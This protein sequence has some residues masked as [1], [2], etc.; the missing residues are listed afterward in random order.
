MITRRSIRYL[1]FIIIVGSVAYLGMA[2]AESDVRMT[3]D[4]IQH[5]HETDSNAP[6]I[7]PRDRVT[8]VVSDRRFQGMNSALMAFAPNGSLLYYTDTFTNYHD[9]DPSPAGQRTIFVTVSD[10]VPPSE[11]SSNHP[12]TRNIFQ[13]I[14]LTTGHTKT[15]YSSLATNKVSRDCHDADRINATHYAVA[16]IADDRALIVNTATDQIDWEWEVNSSY[17]RDS[18]GAYPSDW[19]HMND[20][21]Y[22]PNGR[23]MLSLRN[24][25]QVVFVKPGKGLLTNWTLGA[26]DAHRTLFEAH[27]PDYIPAA[28]GGP[29]VLIADSEND[30]VI[31]Y[32]RT[33]G[34]WK[35]SWIWPDSRMEWPRDADRLP[36][37]HTLITDSN[38]GRVFEVNQQGKTVWQVNVAMPYEAERFGTGDESEGGK[39]AFATHLT[40]TIDGEGLT[41]EQVESYSRAA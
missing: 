3:T 18:G 1:L 31:E 9:V 28:E 22:L 19:T 29:A 17:S 8:I 32:Q 41:R 12:C 13:R 35:A 7:S 15:L 6:V 16:D 38:A 27:N 2:Y 23:I 33:K 30:R 40:P 39:S 20:V 10:I 11:C 4:R 37:G 21:E 34:E 14:N 26:D 25:D 5:A 36:N 24:H